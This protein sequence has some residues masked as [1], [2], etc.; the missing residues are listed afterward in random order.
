[1]SQTVSTGWLKFLTQ[2]F[3]IPELTYLNFSIKFKFNV[4]SLDSEKFQNMIN[5]ILDNQG[6]VWGNYE[7]SGVV[8]GVAILG[9]WSY[10]GFALAR[11]VITIFVTISNSLLLTISVA[12]T[13]VTFLT[14]TKMSQ[15]KILPQI[16]L[17]TDVLKNKSA[18]QFY[19]TYAFYPI[20]NRLQ[21]AQV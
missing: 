10:R 15:Q 19:K 11:R 5:R 1:M 7:L 9:T 2:E 4:R 17:S 13:V 16:F 3:L 20:F 18:Y 8:L 14:A 21:T 6:Q 12:P